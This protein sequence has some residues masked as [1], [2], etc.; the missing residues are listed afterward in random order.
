MDF[1]SF[2][3]SVHFWGGLFSSVSFWLLLSPIVVTFVYEDIYKPQ[4]LHTQEKHEFDYMVYLV[5]HL[6]LLITATIA[7]CVESAGAS[8][9][10][11]R[12]S[13]G[14]LPPMFFVRM[15]G[16]IAGFIA[17]YKYMRS[18]TNISRA[19]E[20]FPAH[21]RAFAIPSTVPAYVRFFV[22]LYF[23]IVAVI[24]L[25]LTAPLVG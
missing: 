25:Y 6:A 1:G 3:L 4:L 13:D 18:P 14:A 24:D 12:S 11:F 7:F 21:N 20:T 2:L 23:V 15:A 8:I 5:V 22:M 19:Y 16:V 10:D 9:S 17:I